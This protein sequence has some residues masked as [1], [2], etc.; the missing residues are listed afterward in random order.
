VP[1]QPVQ[2]ET[3]PE[4]PAEQVVQKPVEA[5]ATGF[6]A[7]QE[8][9]DRPDQAALPEVCPRAAVTSR[10]TLAELRVRRSCR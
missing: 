6:R 1:G 3:P 8:Q 10:V 7:K 5:Q 4:Q 2:D 9:A